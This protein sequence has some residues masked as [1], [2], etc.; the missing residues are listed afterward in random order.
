MELPR[1]S[2]AAALQSIWRNGDL[3]RQLTERD[4]RS[5][6]RGS[7]GGLVWAGVTPLLMLSV[8]TVFFG[9]IFPAKWVTP[10]GSQADFALILFVGLMLHGFVSESLA[11][12]PSLVVGQPN[13][14]RKVVFPLEVLPVVAT[15]TALIHLCI[16]F[17]V[18]MLF[19]VLLRGAPP[20]SEIR[21]SVV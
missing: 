20:W 7:A 18:W 14:V 21:K 9:Q 11:R 4:T 17:L 5:R 2:P 8:Y 3:I 1:Y 16:S 15:G 13:L 12:A 6:Y 10:A 19:Y